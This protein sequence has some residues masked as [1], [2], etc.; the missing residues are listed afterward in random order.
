M[1]AVIGVRI[2]RPH[3]AAP[4]PAA[5][6]CSSHHH[7]P[8]R[9]RRLA[10]PPLAG[11]PTAARPAS[12]SPL[13]A[14]TAIWRAVAPKPAWFPPETGYYAVHGAP[15]AVFSMLG[16]QDGTVVWQVGGAECAHCKRPRAPPWC[17][18]WVSGGGLAG[19][20]WQ[21]QLERRPKAAA[22]CSPPSATHTPRAC[23]WRLPACLLRPGSCSR[24]A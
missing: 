7:Q 20:V 10:R 17:G 19:L 15:P 18:R 22:G 23:S 1:H 5:Q 12:P 9:H 11:V 14:G 6:P 13:C 16:T 8:R 21:A 3:D 4:R 2:A 24:P